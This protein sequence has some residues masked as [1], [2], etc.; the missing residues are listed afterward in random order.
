[1]KLSRRE[2]LKGSA[3]AAVGTAA[4]GMA[5][6]MPVLAE[7]ATVDAESY[8]AQKWSFEIAP[9]PVPEEDLVET[10]E[11]D[12]V[13]VGSGTAGL[14]CANSAI[15]EGLSVILISGSDGPI[16]RGG[17]NGASFS[18][19]MEAAGL[20]KISPFVVEKEIFCMNNI[21]DQK[22]W[23]K[24]YNHS[25][26][27]FDYM[28]DIMEGAGFYTALEQSNLIKETNLYYAPGTS[29]SWVVDDTASNVSQ[30]QPDLVATLSDRLQE[31]GGQVFYG[32][33]GYQLV[34]ED[35]NTGRVDAVIGR[36][37]ADG[38]YAKYVGK[39]AVVIASGD[40]SADREMMLKYCPEYADLVDPEVQ[41]SEQDF[42]RAFV[43][44]GLYK[45]DM[46][47]AALWIGA[48]WQKIRPCGVMVGARSGGATVNRYQNFFGL[49]VDVNGKR[50]MNEYEARA[51]GPLAQSF[52]AK[53]TTFA[54]WNQDWAN[55]FVWYDLSY[56]TQVRDQHIRTPEAMI[57][58]WDS[59]VNDFNYFK[60]DTLEE[61][62]EMAGLPES[63]LDTIAHY[64]EMCDAGEDTEFYK[65]PEFMIPVKE[66]PFYCQKSVHQPLPFYTVLGGLRTNENMQVCDENDE[67]IPGLY[68]VGTGVGDVFAG[69]YSFQIQGINY[70]MNCVTFG[71]LTG[72]YIAENE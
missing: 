47:K 55:H 7:E 3:A 58:E 50:F 28:I 15:D 63:T 66:G 42:N 22:K 62:I 30:N 48:A 14:T 11:A 18:K 10:L 24:W 39:K 67:A 31:K 13:V 1:M 4:A 36:I 61:L 19:A 16:A 65:D 23:Y 43:T 56:A 21:V 72:K 57:E 70:G 27:A 71:Y 52:Q 32:V 29:H 26:E 64:N 34:R 38:T 35:N 45:G 33:A 44:G 5:G 54:I 53:G 12:V 25:Q 60:A 51:L 20:S 68:I 41:N 40:F 69:Y 59:R 8:K 2:F 17:S 9:D 49:L 37:L 46:Q 6:A